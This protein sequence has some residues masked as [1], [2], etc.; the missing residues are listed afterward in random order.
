MTHKK[1]RPKGPPRLVCLNRFGLSKCRLRSLTTASEAKTDKAEAEEGQS[2]GFGDTYLDSIAR[3]TDVIERNRLVVSLKA[4][5]VDAEIDGRAIGDV[6]AEIRE[7][8][9]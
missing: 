2:A 1:R 8:G 7:G 5:S 4:A 9:R 6:V 3:Y